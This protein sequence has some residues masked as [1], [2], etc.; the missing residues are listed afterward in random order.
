MKMNYGTCCPFALVNKYEHTQTNIGGD[1]KWESETVKL[2][3][4]T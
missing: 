1:K 3:C 4:N 2:L